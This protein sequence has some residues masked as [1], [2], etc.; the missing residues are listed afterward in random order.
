MRI[1]FLLIMISSLLIPGCSTTPKKILFP[2]DRPLSSRT[3]AFDPD[4]PGFDDN[5]FIADVSIPDGTLV[6]PFEKFIKTWRVRNTGT[7][8]WDH[9][10]LVFLSGDLLGASGKISLETL[11]PE[12]ECDISI[13]MKA[14]DSPGLYS[15]YWRIM[16]R[17]GVLFGD[18]FWVMI[19]VG[20]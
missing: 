5:K 3:D 16:N 9:Y 2:H 20:D 7:T 4:T 12:K 13:P 8:A 15:G 19:R 14:P 18:T 17:K 11:S 6:K 10:Q 1:A